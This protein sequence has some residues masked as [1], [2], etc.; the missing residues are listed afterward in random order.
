MRIA[1]RPSRASG[2][3]TALT[4]TQL[5][6]LLRAA[7]EREAVIGT[8]RDLE[9]DFETGKLSEEDHAQMRDQL[10]SRAMELLREEREGPKPVAAPRAAFCTECGAGL[11]VQD[12]FCAQCGTRVANAGPDGGSSA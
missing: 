6:T 1:R 12:K 7:L 4:V 10:R 9:E 5:A 8:L 11:R 2:P 3:S